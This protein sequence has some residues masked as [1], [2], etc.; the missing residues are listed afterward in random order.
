MNTSAPESET[1]VLTAPDR[2]SKFTVP[3]IDAS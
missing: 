1:T 2:S 3:S